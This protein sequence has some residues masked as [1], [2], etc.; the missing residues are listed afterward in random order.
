[1]GWNRY[2][3]GGLLYRGALTV[4]AMGCPGGGSGT[5]GVST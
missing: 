5:L 1:L 2:V 3:A 4:K